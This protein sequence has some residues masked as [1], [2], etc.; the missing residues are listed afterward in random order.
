MS[1]VSKKRKWGVASRKRPP[2]G[3]VGGT[4]PA[5][6]PARRARRLARVRVLHGTPPFFQIERTIAPSASGAGAIKVKIVYF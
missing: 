4:P 6:T 5:G 2:L 1:R 3:T